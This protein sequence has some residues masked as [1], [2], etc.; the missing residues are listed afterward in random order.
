MLKR[1]WQGATVCL[2]ALVM[3]GAAD[4]SSRF[5][6]L[7][8]E[9]VCVCSCGQILLECN[10]VGCPDSDRMIGELRQQISSGNSNTAILNW[11]SA[12]YGPTVLAAPIRGGFDNAA[13]IAPMAVFLLAT[14]GTGVLVVLWKKRTAARPVAAGFPNDFTA[15]DDDLRERIRRETE[16]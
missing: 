12:K 11:F 15:G 14:V 9:M 1:W 7:G 3:L 6:R 4:A 13:W 16:Y 2:L 10:H 8:H 5:G